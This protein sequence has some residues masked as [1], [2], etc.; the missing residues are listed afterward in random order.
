MEKLTRQQIDFILDD[1]NMQMIN[2][3]KLL[4]YEILDFLPIEILERMMASLDYSATLKEIFERN[5]NLTVNF[6][7]KYKNKDT[8]LIYIYSGQSSR[9][10]VGGL[11]ENLRIYIINGEIDLVED[12]I[13]NFYDAFIRD[14]EEGMKEMIFRSTE[15]SD[16]F[17]DLYRF[18]ITENMSNKL[19]VFLKLV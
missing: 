6:I 12:I 5:T 17:V 13:I 7:K 1:A 19:Q 10:K 9:L 14:L 4:T 16:L 18:Y 3:D 2:W 15:P 11:F 8:S